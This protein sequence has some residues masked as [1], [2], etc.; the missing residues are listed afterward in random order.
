MVSIEAGRVSSVSPE[1]IKAC[2]PM[3]LTFVITTFLRLVVALKAPSPIFVMFFK[4]AEVMSL[5]PSNSEASSTVPSSGIVMAPV[6]TAPILS[7][8]TFS[9]SFSS[10]PSS[11]SKISPATAP[12]TV[13]AIVTFC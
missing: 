5:L 2:T 6:A 7:D 10:S 3:L 13:T 9:P 1:L 8:T 11:T 4:S 12:F